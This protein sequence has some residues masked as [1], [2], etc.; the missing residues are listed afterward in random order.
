MPDSER[1]FGGIYFCFSLSEVRFEALTIF[2][3]GMLRRVAMVSNSNLF[4]HRH[5]YL[6]LGKTFQD[7]RDCGEFRDEKGNKLEYWNDGIRS[8]AAAAYAVRGASR[9][10]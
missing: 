5:F 2:K 7:W 10:A 1:V 4:H 6:E 8:T 3:T 9:D